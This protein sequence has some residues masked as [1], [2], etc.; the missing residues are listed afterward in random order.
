MIFIVF[1][2]VGVGGMVG[3]KYAIPYFQ[4]QHQ[5]DTSDAKGTKGTINI[6][7]DSWIGYF[8]LCS[9]DFKRRMR[10][11]GYLIKCQD[12]KADYGARFKALEKGD[13]QFAVA[14]L[15]SY[16]LGGKEF[17]YPGTVISVIDESKGG[18]GIVSRK[19]KVKSLDELKSQDGLKVAFTPASPSEFLL[20]AT[21]V[22]FDI[23]SLRKGGNATMIEADGSEDAL[24]KLKSG[25][26]D[27]AVLWEPDLT[28]AREQQDFKVLLSSKDTTKLIVDVLLVSRQYAKENP[29]LVHTF[30][31]NYFRTLKTYRDDRD[32]LRQEVERET[33]LKTKQV[34][35]MLSGVRWVTLRENA[36]A[37]FGVQMAGQMSREDIVDSLESSVD[38]LVDAGTITESPLPG[39]NPYVILNRGFV[40]E[41][42]TKGVGGFKN[43]AQGAAQAQKSF[44]ALSSSAWDQ[45]AEVGTLKIR[46]ITFQ[47]G[48]GSL[49][50]EGQDQLK[51]AASALKHYPNFR[52]VIKGHTGLRG[53]ADANRQLSQSRAESVLNYMVSSLSQD[54][55]RLRAVGFGADQPLKRMPGESNRSYQYRLPRVELYLVSEV[56]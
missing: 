14:T 5:K 7:M 54:Q 17:G 2:V 40:E 11:T 9:K 21:S 33:Q 52:V 43:S 8:P 38:I 32:R 46:P 30:L 1:L 51:K 3:A 37:W 48:T 34:Q 4:G 12:D 49:S 25:D 10:N 6:G 28:R 44:K 41:L 53:D 23:A 15:D 50:D 36:M 16:L 47:S 22:H 56:Y 35:A 29:E 24:D 26:A 45:M 39:E 13:L 55:N 42:F 27:V 19:D 31:R 18:D 20:K